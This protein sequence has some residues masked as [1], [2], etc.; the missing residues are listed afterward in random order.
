MNQDTDYSVAD[1]D[2][3][4]EVSGTVKWFDTARGYGF[5][6]Q[7]A[8]GPDVMLH[9]SCLRQAGLG[10]LQEGASV[11]CEAVKRP[12][13]LQAV[14]VLSYDDSTATP[15]HAERRRE[16]LPS[17]TAVQPVGEFEPAIVK[18]FNRAKGYG[19]VSRG[20][21]T[22]DIFVHME[23]L[24]RCGIRD[25]RQNQAVLVRFGQGP[26]GLMVADIRLR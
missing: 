25:L 13:G 3:L 8:G 7:P 23:F 6:A 4:F 20:P 21:E 17:Q 26:K 5:L 9:Q 19:F 24:R 1:N 14:R 15:A 11:V 18:W 22:P 10:T 2:L 16:L 12:K